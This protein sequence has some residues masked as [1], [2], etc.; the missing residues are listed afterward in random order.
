MSSKKHSNATGPSLR[1][2][3]SKR[4]MQLTSYGTYGKKIGMLWKNYGKAMEFLFLGSVRT[5][6]LKNEKLDFL[7]LFF[8][9][10]D[11]E[12]AE[13]SAPFF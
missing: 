7:L 11:Y 2:S 6:I 8:F 5:L 12:M 13:I 9:N 10:K 4:R 3:A 1:G